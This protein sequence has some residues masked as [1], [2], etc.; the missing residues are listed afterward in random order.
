MSKK[1]CGQQFLEVDDPVSFA[2]QKYQWTTR[3]NFEGTLSSSFQCN[4][5]KLIQFCR[6]VP[7]S[8][9]HSKCFNVM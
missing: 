1:V 7:C 3:N 2:F 6:F 8:L 5:Q 4:R 9:S